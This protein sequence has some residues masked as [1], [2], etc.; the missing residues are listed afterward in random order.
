MCPGFTADPGCNV[1]RQGAM[2]KTAMIDREL[3]KLA[4]N[5]ALQ[6]TRLAKS[7]SIKEQNYTFF[8][9]GK[10]KDEHRTHGV[11]FAVSN[12]LVQEFDNPV[13]VSER[14]ISLTLKQSASPTHLICAYAPTLPSEAAVKDQF[15]NRLAGV[16][17]KIPP[18][19]CVMLLG[20][21]NA[22]VG[23][24]YLAWPNAI[25]RFGVGKIN[26]NGQRFLE[27]CSQHGLCIANT[28]FQQKQHRRVT[29]MHPPSKHWQRLD[30]ALIRRRD[31]GLVRCSRTYHT[32]DGDTDH[33]LVL[34]QMNMPKQKPK[35]KTKREAAP[36]H[37]K[38]EGRRK[39]H[40]IPE[41]VCKEGGCK[42]Y[43]HRTRRELAEPVSCY[44]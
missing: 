24:D 3:A 33:S 9:M 10:A 41:V 31:I 20:D 14:I 11:G 19:D 16:L 32:A 26:E 28:W 44:A 22:H 40:S 27:L 8:W 12:K 13:G 43:R 2:C 36:K 15:Y 4:V 42:Q 18:E 37:C 17:N 34:T 35:P 23:A 5:V 38:N 1:Q 30:L 6:E 39:C 7:G 21:F 25:R 29:W